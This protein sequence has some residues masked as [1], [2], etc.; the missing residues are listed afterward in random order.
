[1]NNLSAKRYILQEQP[2]IDERYWR[3]AMLAQQFQDMGA[4]RVKESPFRL[5]SPE[6]LHQFRHRIAAESNPE[7]VYDPQA[8]RA[9][10]RLFYLH[11]SSSSNNK[12]R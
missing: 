3:L 6:Q 9:Q 4:T 8:I 7:V 11:P 2:I 10:Q 1:M 12:Q 5:L